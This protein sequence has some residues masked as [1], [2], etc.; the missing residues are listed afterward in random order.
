MFR[1]KKDATH[2][3]R[4][5]IRSFAPLIGCIAGLS[6]IAGSGAMQESTT[7]TA[8]QRIDGILTKLQARS[9]GLKDIRCQVHFVENDKINLS[10]RTKIGTLRFMMSEPNPQFLVHFKR[11]EFDGLLGKQEWYLF[12]GRWLYTAIERLKQVTKQE[13]AQP[14]ERLDLFN[15][16]KAPFPVPFGHKKET[17]LRHFDVELA[18]PAHGDPPGTDHIVCVPKATSELRRRYEKLEL[19]VK[20][21][22]H[23]P[24][25]IV[26]TRNDGLE[27]NTADFPDLSDRSINVGI[28][29]NDFA[30]PAAWRKFKEVVERAAVKE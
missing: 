12:D 8:A 7:E 19:F 17:I 2:A 30:K 3:A 23:L 9:D 13:L 24:S 5:C 25:R 22:V 14:G 18:P 27:V 4:N 21:D 16:E 29:A 20:K 1:A 15:L 28:S 6:L 11:I 26:V 10:K